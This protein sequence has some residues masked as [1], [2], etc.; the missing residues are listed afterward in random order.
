[1]A[2]DIISPAIIELLAALKMMKNKMTNPYEPV[3]ELTRGKIVESVHF[4]AAAV[5]DSRGR[6]L[7]SLG[8]PYL[9]TFLRS[10]AKPFQALP[11]IERGGHEKFGLTPREIALMCSSHSGTDEHVEMVKGMQAKIGV[12]ASDLLCGTHYPIHEATSDAMKIRGELPTPYRHNCSGKHTGMLA[13]AKLR[14]APIENYLDFDHPV[15][16]SILQTF[17]EMCV[18]SVESV[19]LGIDGCS[20]PNFAVTLYNAAF[21]YARLCDPYDQAPVRAAACRTISS[22]MMS[23]PDMVGGPGRFDTALMRAGKGAILVKGGAE[24]FQSVGLLPGAIGAGSPGIGIAIKISDGDPSDRARNGVA[25]A[26][27]QALGALDAQQLD[28]LSSFGPQ[29][30]LQNY[31]KLNIGVSRPAFVLDRK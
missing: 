23:H 19:E 31:R 6:L 30:Q 17:A 21:G 25:L 14:A 26:I 4:G 24:G 12:S 1:M 3:F 9:V 8:D 15:Q 29:T 28:E 18:V 13:H 7:A 11:F 20:A 27:L 10:S 5:V 2:C 16:A 22:A